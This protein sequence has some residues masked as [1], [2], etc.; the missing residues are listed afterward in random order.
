MGQET[1]S[2]LRIALT[3]EST[4]NAPLRALLEAEGATVH[5]CPLIRIL[6]PRDAAPLQRCLEDIGAYDWVVLTSANAARAVAGALRGVRVAVIG[7]AQR[8]GKFCFKFRLIYRLS[9]LN[10]YFVV[11]GYSDFEGLLGLA[12]G[13]RV[14]LVAERATGKGM[15]EALVAAGINGARILWPRS[16]LAPLTLMQGLQAHGA[17]VDAPVAYRNEPDAEGA[18]MLKQ[19]IQAG[20]VDAIAFASASAV[21]NA[22]AAVGERLAGLRLYSIGPTTTSAMREAGLSV[23]GES[24]DHSVIGLADVIIHGESRSE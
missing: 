13:A 11:W 8:P 24:A 1:L 3:R 19:L 4:S 12:A 21:H 14:E 2:G 6:P 7:V 20:E 16:E 15:L 10:D 9:V 17:T 18:A 23:A 22:V 5:D